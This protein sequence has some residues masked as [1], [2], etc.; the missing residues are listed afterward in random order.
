MRN[1]LRIFY[2]VFFIGVFLCATM[3]GGSAF[4]QE[5]FPTKPITIIVPWTAGGAHDL[6]ARALQPTLEKILGQPVTVINKPGG[7]ATIGFG[8]VMASAPDGYTLGMIS[9]SFINV[10]YTI[11]AA[12]I[13]YVKF[14]PIVYVGHA[15]N[16]LAVRK[17]AQWNTLKEFLD[18]AKANPGKVSVG[19][20]G[21][22]GTN[23]IVSL[24]I[25]HATGIKFIHVPYK[26]TQPSIIDLL[27]GHV[28]AITAGLTDT[29]SLIRGGKI[30][31]LGVTPDRSKFIPEAQ[32]F[33]ELGMDVDLPAMY[34]F[35]GPKGIPKERVNILYT[36]F[37][38][39]TEA[40]EFKDY[41]EGT[42]S[43]ISV[44]GPEEFGKI[45]QEMDK[46]VKELIT[47]FGIKPE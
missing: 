3:V 8:E 40:K 37:K 25:E 31:P 34:A 44:K 42:G 35:L 28:H 5:K 45:L 13:D 17:E 36:A 19:N 30:K 15:P 14:E 24:A 22:G 38:K 23:H 21:Y 47:S 27:G 4:A 6:T 12:G 46:R 20:G 9:P 32:S 18:Y 41:F 29:F 2:G 16:I 11:P 33:K 1:R 7:G 39:S 26:G 43:T 10:K